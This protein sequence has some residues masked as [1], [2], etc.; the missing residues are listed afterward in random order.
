MTD[1]ASGIA[2]QAACLKLS[3]I[4]LFDFFTAKSA[5]GLA[6]RNPASDE[7]KPN[8]LTLLRQV[9]SN[10]PGACRRSRRRTTTRRDRWD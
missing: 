5:V 6:S 7:D 9:R 1:V 4:G 8:H 3:D 2:I 10:S